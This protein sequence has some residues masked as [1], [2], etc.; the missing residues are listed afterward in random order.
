MGV[1]AICN[2]QI[3]ISA[4][5]TSVAVAAKLMRAFG[6]HALLITDEK[7]G[8]LFAVGILTEEDIVSGIVAKEADPSALTVTDIMSAD[9]RAVRESRS[10]FDTIRLMYEKRLKQV[11][12]LDE[13]GGLIGI[14][15]TDCLFENMAEEL[16]DF[17]A[18]V[19][20]KR[21]TQ[22]KHASH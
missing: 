16:I 21:S 6:S 15:T 5:T 2:R 18:L 11:A 9:F 13:L 20:D 19:L 8:R 14:V 7:D 12:V 1:G 10:V 4:K 3:P 17:S 22:R